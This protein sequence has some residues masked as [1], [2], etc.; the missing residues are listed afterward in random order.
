MGHVKR[1]MEEQDDSGF[2]SD[3]YFDD[4]C[5][6]CIGD[7]ALG[8]FV[9]RSGPIDRCDFCGATEA[10]GMTVGALFHY[11]SACL[12]TE[13]D[14]PINEVGWDKG[15]DSFVQ[16]LDSDELLEA[17]DEPLLNE[18]LRQEFAFS[19][20][21]Q[22]CHRDPYRLE[23][24]EMLLHS[25]GRFA[26]VAKTQRR[27]LIGRG[28]SKPKDARDELL[29]PIEV[30]DAVGGAIRQ[31]DWR[32]IG[33]TSDAEL[34]RARAHA[35][36][37]SHRTPSSLGSP[38][39]TAASH[40]RM[41][42]AGIS[43]FYG[44]HAEE[45]AIAEIRPGADEAVTI[46]RWRP[47]RELVY[48]DLLGA[49]PIPSLFDM[50]A[51]ID[52]TWLRFLAAF[53]DDL[54][55]PIGPDDAPIEY[56][57]TQIVTEFVRDHLQTPDGRPID[58]IRYRSAVDEPNGVCWVVFAGPSDCGAIDDGESRLLLLDP[59]SVVHRMG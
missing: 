41:S 33:R 22:W 13:W 32:M 8:V 24:S 9:S 59:G 40:N 34:V 21:H 16:V 17:V 15:F 30:L 48:L 58:A 31:A 56:I 27:F 46:G 5:D 38:P 51:R 49:R 12:G 19:F 23:H 18:D 37:E 39:P 6:G 25:W 42:G 53:A 29:D 20:Q 57:P 4:A 7:P 2:R 45:T 26:E 11:M 35:P 52:R 55:R 14:D 28:S 10:L 50:T 43:M 3:R 1:W 54:A 44:A 47:G 36:N